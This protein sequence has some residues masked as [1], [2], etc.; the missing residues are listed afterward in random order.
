[1]SVLLLPPIFQ[2]F[3]NNGDPLANGFVDTFAAGT[4]TRLATYTDSTG[5]IAAPNPIQLDSAGRP[6]SGSGAIWGEGAY[7]FI[8]RDA[9][10]VQVGA[11]LD[12][13]ISFN[14]LAD[15]TNAY[16]ETFSG[17]GVQTVFTASADLGTDPKA[18]LVSTASGLQNIIANGDF[19]TDTVWTKGAGWTIGAGVATATGAISTALSQ[20]PILTVIAGQAYAVTYTITR[21]AGG[22][23]PSIGGQNGTERTASGTYREIIIAAATTPVA[24]TGNAFTGTLDNVTITVA[25]NQNMMLLA[26]NAYTVN[27]TSITFAT[28]PALGVNNIDVRAP[29]LLVG[30]ASSAAA[31][32]QLYAANALVS[33]TSAAASAALAATQVKW[34]PAV[35]VATTANITLSGEQVIDGVLT[36]SSRV[37]VKNQ[38]NAIQNGVYVSAAGAWARATDADTWTEIQGQAV[39]TSSGTTNINKSWVNTNEAGGTIGADNITWT[40]LQAFGDM[41]KNVYD[42]A[43]IAQQVVGL[44]AVQ[45]LTNKTLAGTADPAVNNGRLTLTTGVP[46]T[47]ADVT[48]ATSLYFTPYNGNKVSVYSGTQWEMLTFTELTLALGTVISGRPYDVFLDYNAGTPILSLL[49]WTSDTARAT[50]LAYQDGVLCKS[51]TLTQRY[52]GSFYTTS[53]TQTADAVATRYLYNEYNAVVRGAASQISTANYIYTTATWRPANANTTNGDGRFSFIIG[54]VKDRVNIMASRAAVNTTNIL[55]TNGIALNGVTNAEL[56][57]TLGASALGAIATT[58]CHASATPRLGLN[59]VQAMETSV[60]SGVTTWYGGATGGGMT[61]AIVM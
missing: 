60:A 16:A 42:P 10:G 31:L 38:T 52:L 50:A 3:D 57:G 18:L 22:L 24:F 6:T 13:V 49:A 14:S 4:T 59:F 12:N 25:T 21:S 46:V 44:T 34:K 41:S 32:A 55:H 48:G 27:G 2:F 5:T 40:Q 23:I 28:P 17:N 37:L 7:K 56:V 54:N 45:T 26:A 36:S 8:V 30:A 58:P 43:N 29:S 47:T 11:T 61:A 15:A 33:Q 39:F 9:N 53:T 19:A 51:G 20:G 35:V 1:M